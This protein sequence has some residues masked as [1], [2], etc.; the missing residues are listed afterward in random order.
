MLDWIAH[1]GVIKFWFFFQNSRIFFHDSHSFGFRNKI[2]YEKDKPLAILFNNATTSFKD[3]VQ[4]QLKKLDTK[5][6]SVTKSTT[7][8]EA[9]KCRNTD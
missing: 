5:V 6:Q 8:Y 9:V 3:V 1:A 7:I 2:R 4:L